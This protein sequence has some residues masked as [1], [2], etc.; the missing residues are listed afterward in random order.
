MNLSFINLVDRAGIVTF[1]ALALWL[2]VTAILLLP[3]SV[4]AA[5]RTLGVITAL[6]HPPRTPADT[7]GRAG[8]DT[9]R[10]PA[11]AGPRP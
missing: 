10:Q 6:A 4:P 5:T 3:T 8:R 7:D 2:L 9:P 1:G 11:A